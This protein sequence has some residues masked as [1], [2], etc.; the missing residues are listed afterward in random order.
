M[1][2]K[3]KQAIP[4]FKKPPFKMPPDPCGD[5]KKAAAIVAQVLVHFGQGYGSTGAQ[6]F[7]TP[8]DLALFHRLLL[9]S[10]LKN[11]ATLN[12]DTD[13][14]GRDM[15]CS[16]AFQHGVLAKAAAGN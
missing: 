5:V 13:Q 4:L 8:A 6:I 7:A 15:V 12:W 11:L 1:Q 10:T 3:F 16:A 9:K 2:G 14:P